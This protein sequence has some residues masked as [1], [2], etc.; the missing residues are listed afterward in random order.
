MGAGND[1][2]KKL[3]QKKQHNG[4]KHLNT[5]FDLINVYSYLINR[6]QNTD[7]RSRHPWISISLDYISTNRILEAIYLKYNNSLLM[8]IHCFN[9][10]DAY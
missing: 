5:L 1:V 10:D 4:R 9:T 2:N 7:V 3:H 8:A 6:T